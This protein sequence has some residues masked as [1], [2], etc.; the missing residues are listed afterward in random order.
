MGSQCSTVHVDWE[1]VTM[2]SQW[3]TVLNP[4]PSVVLMNVVIPPSIR[5]MNRVTGRTS[6]P[7]K[8]WQ[9]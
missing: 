1:E 2:G 8:Q 9:Y 4:F 5:T 6:H 7:R 3:S